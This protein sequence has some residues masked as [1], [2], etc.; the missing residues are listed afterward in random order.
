MLFLVDVFST[1][2]MLGVQRD[3]IRNKTM[4]KDPNEK[5]ERAN[6]NNNSAMHGEQ[7]EHRTK[8]ERN[9]QFRTESTTT[10]HKTYDELISIN[11]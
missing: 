11:H 1:Q 8:N 6:A 9:T 10:T 4:T 3:D 7:K 2:Q 5:Q